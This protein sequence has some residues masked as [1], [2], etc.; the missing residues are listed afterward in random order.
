MEAPR[1]GAGSIISSLVILLMN[2]SVIKDSQIAIILSLLLGGMMYVVV[3]KLIPQ[4]ARDYRFATRTGRNLFRTVLQTLRIALMFLMLY[5]CASFVVHGY[6]DSP[7]LILAL[8]LLLYVPA[9][10]YSCDRVPPWEFARRYA[11]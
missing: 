2:V 6:E 10:L 9:Y 5:S 4:L 7:S 1:L 3:T 11:R 8:G